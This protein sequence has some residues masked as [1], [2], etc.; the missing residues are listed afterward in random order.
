MET[1]RELYPDNDNVPA[2][3]GNSSGPPGDRRLSQQVSSGLSKPPRYDE[4]VNNRMKGFQEYNRRS[5]QQD[6]AGTSELGMHG[7]KPNF[8]ES[9]RRPS[10]QIDLGRP[11][12]KEFGRRPSQQ[13]DVRRSNPLEKPRLGEYGR[14]PSQIDLRKSRSGEY[15]RRLSQQGDI[16][17]KFP[18]SRSPQQPI[19]TRPAYDHYRRRP[20]QQAEISMPSDRA[21]MRRPSQQFVTN[22]DG[23]Q[24]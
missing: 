6:L 1:N 21:F 8:G 12:F 13:I 23:I 16:G 3:K 9:G 5:S 4:G 22:F 14:R 20:S 15:A 24:E 18:P 11:N 10:Q 2:S 17:G 19:N 7:V